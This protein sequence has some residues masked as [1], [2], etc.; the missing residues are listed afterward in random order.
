MTGGRKVLVS[1]MTQYKIKG[2]LHV[3]ETVEDGRVTLLYSMDA[4]SVE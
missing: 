4:D 3:K 2:T 1:Q